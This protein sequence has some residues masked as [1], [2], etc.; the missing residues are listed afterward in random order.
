MRATEIEY[1]AT[2]QFGRFQAL[3]EWLH[4]L[5]LLMVRE[6]RS[7]FSSDPLGYAWAFI[8]PIVW[9]ATIAT[10]FYY[11]GRQTPILTDINSFLMAGML[12]YIV[13]RFTASSAMRALKAQRFMIFFANIRQEDIILAT[14]LLELANSVVIYALLLLGNYALFGHFEMADPTTAL[15]GFLLAWGLGASFGHM[16]AAFSIITEA[17]VRIVPIILRPMFW[18][19]G[20]FYVANEVP[21]IVLQWLQYNPL[22]QAIEIMRNGVFHSYE[23][24]IAN[25]FIPVTFIIAFNLLAQAVKLKTRM[26]VSDE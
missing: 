24:R 19:S 14:V 6:V 18:L 10:V 5:H 17:T 23:S 15:F 11:V 22:F 2:S 21:G 7:R 25:V 4:V 9:I 16:A 26:I 12:P 3:G 20:V 8:T 1:P 13:F